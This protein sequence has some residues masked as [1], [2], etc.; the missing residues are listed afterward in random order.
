MRHIWMILI[1]MAMVACATDAGGGGSGSGSGSGSNLT[2][3]GQGDSCQQNGD[4]MTDF[5]CVE[6]QDG[7]PRICLRTCTGNIDCDLDY[8]CCGLANVLED[9]CVPSNFDNGMCME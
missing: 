4:C 2:K 8:H 6:E 7:D 1:S 5:A 9:V 3:G